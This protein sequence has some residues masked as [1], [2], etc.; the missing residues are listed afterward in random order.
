MG[1]FASEGGE[2]GQSMRDKRGACG[3]RPRNYGQSYILL[4]TEYLRSSTHFSYPSG[5]LLSA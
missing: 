3:Q 1:V 2:R 5:D 4:C